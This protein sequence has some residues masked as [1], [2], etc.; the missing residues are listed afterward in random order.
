MKTISKPLTATVGL[1]IACAMNC[2][3]SLIS[4]LGILDLNANGGI[5]PATG[6]AWQAGDQYR[7]IFATSVGLEATSTNIEDYNTFIQ[8]AANASPLGLSS[9]TWRVL[10]ST[11]TVDARDNTN[12]NSSGGD[13]S[14]ESFWLMNGT[15][16]I[17]NDYADFYDGHTNTESINISETGGAPLD[18]GNFQSLWTGSDG[19]GQRK[20]DR[21]L[22]AAGGLT[23]GGLFCTC[24]SASQWIDRFDLD[25]TEPRAFYGVSEPLTVMNTIPEPSTFGLLG[26]AGLVL[27]LHRRRFTHR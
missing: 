22:G 16:K 6:T 5:N 12:T 23:K 8:N 26:F 19:S 10:G 17:A 20:N 21:W 14:G 4:E 25:N 11:E 15:T 1:L 18:T 2:Q 24:A 7:L 27:L 9:V 13:G 3:A